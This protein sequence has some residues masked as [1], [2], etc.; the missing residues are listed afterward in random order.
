MS[1][2]DRKRVVMDTLVEMVTEVLGDHEPL[3]P[4]AAATAFRDDL[5]FDSI[6]FIALAELIQDRYD[7]VNFVTWIQGKPMEEI[8]L[9]RVGGVAAFVVASTPG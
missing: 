6:Q 4:I 2:D 5:A 3:E 7:D 1:T 8:V 9:L